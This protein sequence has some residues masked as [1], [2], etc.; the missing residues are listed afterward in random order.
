MKQNIDNLIKQKSRFIFSIYKLDNETS[1]NSI[2]TEIKNTLKN[3][4]KNK[5]NIRKLEI[6]KKG[7][8]GFVFSYTTRPQWVDALS[9][10]FPDNNFDFNN[11]NI[12]FILLKTIK[13]NDKENIYTVCGGQGYNL[14][15]EHIEKN[16]GLNL[17]P[18]L[19]NNTDR[20]VK[21]VSE[22]RLFGN[23]IYNSRMNKSSTNII[24]ESGFS[25]VYTELG[26]IGDEDIQSELGIKCDEDEDIVIYNKHS[27]KI[28]KSISIDELSEIITNID[29][30]HNKK[31]NFSL[32]PFKLI[33]K[34]KYKK[35][36]VDKLFFDVF[37]EK[38]TE[39]FDFNIV[40]INYEKY[41][42]NF[43]FKIEYR[44]AKLLQ[45]D[46]AIEWKDMWR[47]F[48]DLYDSKITHN[49]FKDLIFKGKLITY[50]EN[51]NETLNSEIIN[52]LNG[53]LVDEEND[54]MFFLMNG[55]WYVFDKDY[56]EIVDEEFNELVI[57]SENYVNENII[58]DFEELITVWRD[59][60]GY[61]LI[62]S[63]YNEKFK[64]NEEIIYAN[65]S[66]VNWVEIAD[67][68][69]YDENTLYLLCLKRIYGGGGCRDLYNQIEA[70]YSLVHNRLINNIDGSLKEYYKK[71]EDKNENE[72]IPYEEF[73]ELFK[74]KICFVAGFLRNFLNDSR[75]N[76]YPKILAN[77]L[78]KKIENEGF[79]FVLMD[80]NFD[81]YHH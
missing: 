30:I 74:K 41:L 26:I 63:D 79:E 70:S 42:S 37:S 18:R 40:G 56:T 81:N 12:S 27:I 6:N 49:D 75:G 57:K 16:F 65:E 36:D 45:S 21:Q 59:N 53:Y 15:S 77:I 1:E 52:C 13:N 7:F 35:S 23:L 10:L 34:T 8:R 3:K 19:I 11:S 20:V 25:N 2:L 48:W 55:E 58:N 31:M 43:E 32:I 29:I 33:K 80:F 78:N 54:E 67:L 62:E 72:I 73:K 71:I 64:D 14:I 76:Y 39:L 66:H 28:S 69:V 47:E 46:N 50:D 4:E 60:G 17:V 24:H 9:E 22:N 5:D 38:N 68:I 61:S 51:T 44:G